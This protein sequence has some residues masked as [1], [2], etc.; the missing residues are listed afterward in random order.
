MATEKKK[1]K[2]VLYKNTENS[3]NGKTIAK[4][5][6][7]RPM[8]KRELAD[9]ISF[10]YGIHAKFYYD[11]KIGIYSIFKTSRLWL[12]GGH[13]YVLSIERK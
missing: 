11:G 5:Q 8:T 3:F 6:A 12:Q 9:H 13:Y 2:F 4:G 7:P 1:W 10:I